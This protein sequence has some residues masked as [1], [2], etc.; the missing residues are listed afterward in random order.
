MR[1]PFTFVLVGALAIVLAFLTLPL[2]AIF[3]DAG[4]G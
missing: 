4:T 3:V 2:V 1:S